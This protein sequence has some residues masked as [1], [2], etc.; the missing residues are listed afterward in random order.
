MSL[1][2]S[3]S[4]AAG[5]FFRA[6]PRKAICETR[7]IGGSGDGELEDR[8]GRGRWTFAAVVFFAEVW[9]IP[10]RAVCVIFPLQEWTG[11]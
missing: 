5:L 3:K 4:N 1:F 9:G 8:G 7:R 10:L 2:P 6:I 11:R